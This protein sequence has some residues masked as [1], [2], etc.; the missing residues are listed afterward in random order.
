MSLAVTHLKASAIPDG[1]D[2]SQVQP[3]D[4][5]A[6]HVLAGVVSVA[7]GGT[8]ISGY[9]IGDILYASG[10][11]ALS[12]LG[13]VA[14]GQVMVSGAIPAWSASPTL[15]S[16]TNNGASLTIGTVSDHSVSI[17]VNNTTPWQIDN[18]SGSVGSGSAYAIFPSTDNGPSLGTPSKRL[19]SGYFATA[20]VVGTNPA[21]SGWLRGPNAASLYQRNAANNA[22]VPILG[23]SSSNVLV[24][25][26]TA[27]GGNL[28][29]MSFNVGAGS[30]LLTN[31][32]VASF[33]VQL[34]GTT[35]SFPALK[36]SSATLAFVLADDSGDAN[37][38]AK[39]ATFSNHI[40]IAGEYYILGQGGVGVGFGAVATSWN[41]DGTSQWVPGADNIYPIGSTALR[42]SL[43]YS[44]GGFIAGTN[45]AAAG[46]LRIANNAFAMA[47][48][49]ANSAD[50]SLIGVD[51]SN[52]I[53]VGDNTSAILKLNGSGVRLPGT[54]ID[55]VAS[56]TLQG[57]ALVTRDTGDLSL[58]TTTSGNIVLSPVGDIKWGKALVAL[59]VG[60][61]ATLGLI[62]ASGPATSTQNSWMRVLDS[63]GAAFFVPAFK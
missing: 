59:G 18:S 28:A 46:A 22:D 58:S 30:F 20:L 41:V 14:A 61:P 7:Q 2:P 3:S 35:S 9:T 52:Q 5:N 6:A 25:G 54:G 62:G 10:A 37:I 13:I 32:S 11:S 40:V 8:G 43:V 57:S 29:G 48:N 49:A 55:G 51:A 1:S 26:D 38:T 36:R 45:P 34:G 12:A 21:G 33:L 42:P 16:V 39:G 23:F 19:Q 27:S 15:T 63:T 4:W 31:Q 47:R 56:I 44:A 24:I 50:Y 17:K 53:T 60:A